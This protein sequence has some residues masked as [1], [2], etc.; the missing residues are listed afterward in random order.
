MFKLLSVALLAIATPGVLAASTLQPGYWE[1]KYAV[2]GIG[3]T[4]KW[5]IRA[6]DIEKFIHGPSNHI[7]TCTYPIN[8]AQG[9]RVHFEGE[10]RSRKGR[11]AYIQG[12]G[13]YSPSTLRLQVRIKGGVKLA[14]IPITITPVMKARRLGDTCPADAK[15]FK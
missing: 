15:A 13:T 7:Y 11:H 6:K 3:K 8:E 9:G 10:C 2:A 12:E 4:E 14:G 1:A 5:C